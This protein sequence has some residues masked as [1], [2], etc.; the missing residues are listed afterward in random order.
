MTLGRILA[1]LTFVLCGLAVAGGSQPGDGSNGEWTIRK[2]DNPGWVVFGLVEHHPGGKYSD[3]DDWPASSFPGVDFSKPGRQ[4][5]HFTIARE[6]GKIECEGSLD[7]GEGS[8][9]F[10][11]QPDPDYAREMQQLGILVDGPKQYRMAVMD[12]SLKFTRQMKA[13]HLTGLDADRLVEFRIHNVDT[14]F[15][16]YLRAAGVRVSDSA[17]LVDEDKPPVT[18]YDVQIVQRA[19]ELLDSPSQW[20]RADTRECPAE[21]KTLSLY[22]AL[23]KATDEVTGKF[24]HR[25]AAMQEARFVIDEIAPN[26]TSY[27]HRLMDY[28]NDPTTTFDDV[29]KFFRLLE[30]RIAKRV[31]EESQ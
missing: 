17:M 6:A 24:E 16:A 27:H 4:D 10:H 14:A 11:F 19:R 29:Q 22:C 12:V 5:V 1:F 21:A 2:D 25:G 31:K 9:T 18:K 30:E 7:N 23:K 13:E 3:E 20:N 26:R 28:N 15:I 8:G